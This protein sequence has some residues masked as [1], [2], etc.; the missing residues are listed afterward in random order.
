MIKEQ[1]Q[2]YLALLDL[3]CKVSG[4][5]KSIPTVDPNRLRDAEGLG[6][7]FCFHSTSVFY[8]A[9]GT[10]IKDFPLGEINCVDFASISVVAR[11]AFEAFL[12]FNHVFVAPRTNQLRKFRYWAWLLSGLCERQKFPVT[13]PGHRKQKEN[14]KKEMKELH[15]KLCSNPEF[16][17]LSKNQKANIEKGR[18]RLNGWKK[19]A[20]ETG[21]DE[22]HASIIYAYLCGYSHSDSLSVLQIYHAKLRE[23]Q[24]RLF[25]IAVQ[26]TMITTANMIFLYCDLFPDGKNALAKNPEAAQIA[27]EWRSIGQGKHD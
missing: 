14:E 2:E 12:T 6:V 3:F 10:I 22:L 5:T 20:R 17:R 11:A 27:R 7:K 18:W 24:E 23:Q 21:L 19:M 8:L 16:I 13:T 4:E 1:E 9:R 26:N 15:K 25:R